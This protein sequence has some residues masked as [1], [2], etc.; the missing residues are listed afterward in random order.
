MD[1]RTWSSNNSTE[2]EMEF[3]N[4]KL[5]G[6][7]NLLKTNKVSEGVVLSVDFN[8]S[9]KVGDEA[10]TL[11]EVVDL[12]IPEKLLLEFCKQTLNMLEN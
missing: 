5:E 10:V 12:I 7:I 11:V 1:V 8:E 3:D 4:G 9:G 2:V 6:F